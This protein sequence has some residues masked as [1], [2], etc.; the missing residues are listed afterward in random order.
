MKAHIYGDACI[1]DNSKKSLVFNRKQF[2][3]LNKYVSNRYN[4]KETVKSILASDYDN[5][6]ETTKIIENNVTSFIRKI[7]REL[8]Y[9][10]DEMQVSGEFGKYYPR[11]LNI[12]LTNSCNFMCGHC[13]KC[14]GPKNKIF[15]NSNIID[16]ICD[17][18]ANKIQVIH[19]T[20][21]EPLSHP[22]INDIILKLNNSGF[23]INI[24]TN[25]SLHK[26]ISDDNLR[27]INNFQVSVYGCNRET[28]IDNTL[29]DFF[30]DV[31]CFFD[32]LD[33]LKIKYDVSFIANESY[34]NYFKEYN[35]FINNLNYNKLICGFAFFAGR[36]LNDRENKWMLSIDKQEKAEMYLKELRNY[37]AQKNIKVGNEFKCSA[38]TESYSIS[39]NGDIYLC[40]VLGKSVGKIGNFTDL[41]K[42]F[43][44][45]DFNINAYMKNHSNK[46]DYICPYSTKGQC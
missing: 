5:D 17:N 13:Y 8:E 1:I 37:F 10:I 21:G 22:E 9:K 40:Q 20:G 33:L 31:S 29:G 28:Y 30:D 41:E 15:I 4:I 3:L 11:Y 19:L 16:Y 35:D 6:D 7:E 44:K 26:K 39:E 24:T 14:A 18:Y 12:E 38:G 46:I 43:E 34:L 23:T 25:G 32:R 36:A 2:E 45:N 42:R 27:R